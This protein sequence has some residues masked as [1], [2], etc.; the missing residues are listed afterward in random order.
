M[1]KNL[2]KNIDCMPNLKNFTLFFDAK[3]EKEFHLNFVKKLLSLNLNKI[4]FIIEEH[5]DPY[6]I[7]PLF[8]KNIIKIFIHLMK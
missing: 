6:I 3:V 8:E 7:Y 2:Y 5:L 1:L 4:Y